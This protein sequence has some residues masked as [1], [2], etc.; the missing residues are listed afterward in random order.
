MTA[1]N[2]CLFV[3]GLSTPNMLA[4]LCHYTNYC[5]M[6]YYMMA[7]HAQP[8]QVVLV[9]R[10]QVHDRG[11]CVDAAAVSVWTTVHSN[12]MCTV[13][14]RCEW[15]CGSRDDAGP[16]TSTDTARSGNTSHHRVSSSESTYAKKHSYHIIIIIKNKI[17]TS[18]DTS[19]ILTS[20]VGDVWDTLNTYGR[21]QWSK[22]D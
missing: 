15:G 17:K 8:S 14:P 2:N 6:L 7:A 20:V 9:G 19:D 22:D 12:H 11:W 3:T 18:V 13:S 1:E 21:K 16:E 4:K 5:T 10:S